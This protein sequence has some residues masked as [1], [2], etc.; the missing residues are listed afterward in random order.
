MSNADIMFVPI[1][2]ILMCMPADLAETRINWPTLRFSGMGN[3]WRQCERR[4][5]NIM[6]LTFAN[7]LD[8]DYFDQ[9][10]V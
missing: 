9:D 4:M 7:E 1:I 3:K 10:L 6:N 8:V 5:N 2:D